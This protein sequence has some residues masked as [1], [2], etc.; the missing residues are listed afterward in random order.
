MLVGRMKSVT[1][2]ERLKKRSEKQGN[3]WNIARRGNWREEVEER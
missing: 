2:R 1:D 3:Y